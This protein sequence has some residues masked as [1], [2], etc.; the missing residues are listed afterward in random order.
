MILVDESNIMMFKKTQTSQKDLFEN[1]Q[2][3]CTETETINNTVMH[4][5]IDF[6][7]H[8]NKDTSEPD[9]WNS[10]KVI[11]LLIIIIY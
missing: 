9:S 5:Y 10:A 2:L 7:N 1:M 4:E 3:N 6:E 11:Y 8:S